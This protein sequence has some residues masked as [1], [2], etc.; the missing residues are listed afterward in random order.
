[1]KLC[2]SSLHFSYSKYTSASSPLL[3]KPQSTEKSEK[4]MKVS[5][6]VDMIDA[7]DSFIFK[8]NYQ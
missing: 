2:R 8:E 3:G 1:M 6:F 5:D 4:S 7:V